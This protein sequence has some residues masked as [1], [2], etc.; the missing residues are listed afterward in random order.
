M[1]NLCLL[2]SFLLLCG[3]A[4]AGEQIML[5]SDGSHSNQN[6]INE[7]LKNG[8]VY[9]NAGVY[10]VDDTIIIG[11]NR[12][13]TGDK[14]AIIHV[15]GGSSQYFVGLKGVISCN[16]VVNDVEISNIQIDGNIGNLPKNY[17]NSRSDTSH[18][19]EKLIILHGY[20]NQFAKNIKLHDLKLYNSFSDGCYLLFCENVEVYNNFISNTQHEGVYLSCVKNGL[21]YNNKIAAICSDAGRLDNCQNCKVYDNYFF[22]YNGESYGQYKGGQAGLQIAN[23]GSSKGYNAANKPQ[24][25]DRIEV[26]NNVFADPGRQAIW[27]HNYDGS[28]FVHDN[29]FID[30]DELETQGIPVGD[31]SSNVSYDNPPSVE[32]SERI[33][34]SIFNVMYLDFTTQAGENDTIVF[35][36]GK[37]TTYSKAPWTVEQHLSNGNPSTLVYGDTDGLTKV[38]FEVNG[39]KAIHT[40]ML[41]ERKGLKVIYTNVSAWDGDI[42][43]QGD[44]IYLNGIV[45][46]KDIKVKCYTPKETFEPSLIT[47]Q[48]EPP[49]SLF[50]PILKWFFLV[51]L[52]C[53]VYCIFV[54]KHT[55]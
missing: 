15:W 8:D 48:T 47:T 28:V 55:Y 12:V 16:E 46:S 22:S 53:F 6:Q 23:S 17:A 11:S 43:H 3:L 20:S 2:L 30:T 44:A 54:I 50:S 37:N 21:F 25:T 49:K 33:F 7:A 41:G 34:N 24:F 1:K 13:L 29:S 4:N 35:P 26:Y 10:E 36:N 32:M 9:L 42:S 52:L 39:K 19:C 27:L 38:E 51:L 14:N 18:D 5:S 40:L 31:I 45:D